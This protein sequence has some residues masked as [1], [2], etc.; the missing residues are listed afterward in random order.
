MT[1]SQLNTIFAG[2]SNRKACAIIETESSDGTKSKQWQN[3]GTV[4]DQVL[5]SR[6]T[7]DPSLENLSNGLSPTEP[8]ETISDRSMHGKFYNITLLHVF[9]ALSP[10][11]IVLES[12]EILL[13][14]A[15][16]NTAAAGSI[17]EANT[18]RD[19]SLSVGSSSEIPVVSVN[20]EQCNAAERTDL[21]LDDSCNSLP[22]DSSTDKQIVTTVNGKFTWPNVYQF[23]SSIR[24]SE[25]KIL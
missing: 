17:S 24:S 9:C 14:F 8:V 20:K 3:G 6:G 4:N 21:L 16:G 7:R 5:E 11:F 15:V 18:Q 10:N 25:N 22:T 2:E 23:F 13:F 1:K 12:Q 19:I